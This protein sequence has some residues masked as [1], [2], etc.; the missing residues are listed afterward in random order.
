[1][2]LG[3]IA[4]VAHESSAAAAA[5]PAPTPGVPPIPIPIVSGHRYEVTLT[6]GGPTTAA[7][8]LANVV[9]N[10]QA[11]LNAVAPN[12]YAFVHAIAPNSHQ[13]VYV[14]DAIGGPDG[15][16]H[17]ESPQ[18]FY[19]DLNA[20]SM[21]GIGVT[22]LDLGPSPTGAPAPPPGPTPGPPG[23]ITPPAGA[24][25]LA[26]L[27]TDPALV[28]YAQVALAALLTKGVIRSAGGAVVPN[29]NPSDPPTLAAISA[30]QA[31]QPQVPQTGA[32]DFAS[33]A[34]AVVLALLAGATLGANQ[35]VIDPAIVR[36]AQGA[37]AKAIGFGQFPNIDYGVGQVTGDPSDGAWRAALAAAM[38]PYA[39]VAATDGSLTLPTLGLVLASA[40]APPA[41]NG[42][43]PVTPA[44]RTT[45]VEI[46]IAQQMI[47]ALG[48]L[49]GYDF[50]AAYK[51]L[52]VTGDPTDPQTT[53]AVQLYQSRQV[54]LQ[55]RTTPGVLD[56][57]T[58]S[59]IVGARIA[60]SSAGSVPPK[61]LRGTDVTSSAVMAGLQE[62]LGVAL[63]G[64]FSAT[65]IVY[66]EEPSGQITA[67]FFSA[68]SKLL[69][70][71]N[72]GTAPNGYTLGGSSIDY[73]LFATIFIVAY[74]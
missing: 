61:A 12:E 69:T 21:G 10:I 26:S 18:T 62:A 59:S 20:A 30:L 15:S 14:V 57:L 13:V 68:L 72:A 33:W 7:A 64:R 39:S 5:P 63:R 53:A 50:L 16:T 65:G 46:A 17:G 42:V 45:A 11:G 9:P 60:A 31:S 28:T 1:V 54:G 49:P 25:S 74:M 29:G 41:G 66:A 8:L 32:L 35:T 40:I 6:F 3:G 44:T 58:F 22:V 36:L 27:V 71:I 55:H 48:S 23:P 24:L 37:L 34:S 51:G 2:L 52:A 73:Y 19:A 56:Y 47:S 43:I 67:P 70:I 4:L 38:K